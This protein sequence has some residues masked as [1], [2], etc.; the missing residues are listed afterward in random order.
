MVMM[1]TARKMEE[2]SIQPFSKPSLMMP[3]I[4]E[5]KAASKSN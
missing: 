2:P 3:I 5:T 4:N 1:N